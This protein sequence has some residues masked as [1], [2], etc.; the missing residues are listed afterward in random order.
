[1]AG[2]QQ[3]SAAL[4]HQS[5]SV[6]ASLL[7][8]WPCAALGSSGWMG[9]PGQNTRRRGIC[10]VYLPPCFHVTC[11]SCDCQCIL[12]VPKMLLLAHSENHARLSP[13]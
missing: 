10:W 4:L 12:S 7:L 2:S 6:V 5:G 13:F 11:G 1:M 3:Q 8:P 9:M